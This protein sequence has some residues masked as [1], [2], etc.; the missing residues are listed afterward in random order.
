MRALRTLRTTLVAAGA[1][2]VLAASASGAFAAAAPEAA[3]V[4]HASAPCKDKRVPVKTVRLA[5]KVSVAKV[6]KTGKHRFVAEIWAKGTKYGTLVAKDH[7]ARGQ[8]NG[9]HVTLHPNGRVTSWIERAQPELRPAAERILVSTTTLAD[10][11]STAKVY[12]LSAHHY[13]AD[14]YANGTKYGTLVAKDHAARGQ[15][16]GLHVLLQPDGRVTSWVDD[17]PGTS[18]AEPTVHVQVDRQARQ[19]K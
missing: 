7:A 13:E 11:T 10:D 12:R 8:N 17:A 1:T 4:A 14:V 9:L 19:G 18:A 16:N 15:N 5:D 2:A 6:Y 3:P